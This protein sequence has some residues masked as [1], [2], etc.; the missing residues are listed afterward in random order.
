M[1]KHIIIEALDNYEEASKDYEMTIKLNKEHDYAFN[2]LGSCYVKLKEY[3]KALENFYKALEINSKLALPYNN[4]GEVKSRLDLKEKN[5]I[6]NY[7]KL[8]SEALEYF[9]KSYKM[10]LTNNDEYEINAI[11][12][13]MKELAHENIEPAIEFLKNNNIDY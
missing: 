13:N 5:N 11:I 7:N 2:N 9:N 1:M 12:D 10:A 4:I 8:N 3:D 6:E